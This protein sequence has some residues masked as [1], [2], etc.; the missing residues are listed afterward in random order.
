MQL[1]LIVRV[2]TC[3]TCPLHMHIYD[4]AGLGIG[5]GGLYASIIYM[6]NKKNII[7]YYVVM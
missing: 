4:L 6:L 1:A 5:E 7:N 2:Q 3:P